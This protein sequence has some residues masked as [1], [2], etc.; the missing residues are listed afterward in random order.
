VEHQALAS[1]GAA[2]AR[3]CNCEGRA[4]LR[5]VRGQ[6]VRAA[7]G[8]LQHWSLVA[9]WWAQGLVGREGMVMTDGRGGGGDF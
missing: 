1:A 9:R 4:W 2:A 5:E 3:A 8:C 7:A 6:W